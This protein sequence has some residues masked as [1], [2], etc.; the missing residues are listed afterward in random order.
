MG[1][2][3]K[4]ALKWTV[5]ESVTSPA[6]AG[7]PLGKVPDMAQRTCSIEACETNAWARGWCRAHYQ[8]WYLKGTPTPEPR[9][10]KMSLPC[11]VLGCVRLANARGW[12]LM[13]YKRWRNNGDPNV[14][15]R[16]ECGAGFIDKNGYVRITRDGRQVFAHRAIMEDVTIT[17]LKIWNSGLSRNLTVSARSTWRDGLSRPIRN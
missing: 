10:P 3:D 1:W 17:G 13:H 8:R 5:P 14:A 9:V 7:Q 16:A 12:C 11:S 4:L 2:S 15:R 6:P